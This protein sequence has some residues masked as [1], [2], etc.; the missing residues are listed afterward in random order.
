MNRIAKWDNLKAV[1]VYLVILGH[2]VD[3]FTKDSVNMRRIFLFI[4]IFHMP[5]FLFISGLFSKRNIDERRYYKMF[6][7]LVMYLFIKVLIWL[8]NVWIEGNTSFSL[9]T[10]SSIPWYVFALFVF[11]LITVFLKQIDCRWVMVFVVIL[12]CMA[13]Y[14]RKLNDTLV[15]LRILVYYPF[16]YAGYLCDTAKLEKI[17]DSKKLRILSVILLVILMVVVYSQI[18]HIYWLRPLLTGRNAYE[19]LGEWANY[20]FLLRLCYYFF[21]AVTVLTVIAVVP[22]NRIPV[23][24]KLGQRSFQIYALHSVF[25]KFFLFGLKGEKLLKGISSRYQI[26]LFILF[27]MLIMLLCSF[28]WIEKILKVIIYP[29]TQKDKE[30]K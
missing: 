11:S 25:I 12:G 21:V 27:S 4:Y 13:G 7:Y 6:S 2:I 1:L 5:C 18:D 22:K 3:Y 29:K 17:T 15:G 26:L 16:F 10:E 23:I 20:G 30:M 14:D 28:G 24:T 8:V 19:K 9:L